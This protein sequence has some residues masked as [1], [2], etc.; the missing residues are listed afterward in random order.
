RRPQKEEKKEKAR[1]QRN[2]ERAAPR[3]TA[4][5]L[6]SWRPLSRPGFTGG[7]ED[8]RSARFF[9]VRGAMRRT[10]TAQPSCMAVRLETQ[11][12]WPRGP[13]VLPSSR[14]PVKS[15]IVLHGP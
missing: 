7:W 5:Q 11:E 2:R 15:R 14:P 9:V 1:R 13:P 4:S 6:T 12:F 8:G 10:E 3:R